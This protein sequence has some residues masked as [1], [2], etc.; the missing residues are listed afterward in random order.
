MT[1]DTFIGKLCTHPSQA[2]YVGNDHVPSNGFMKASLAIVAAAPL[3]A[4]WHWVSHEESSKRFRIKKK[5]TGSKG[6]VYTRLI[7]T[8][9]MFDGFIR[10]KIDS[11][12]RTCYES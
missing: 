8:H 12:G 6:V 4:A 11:V 3:V 2:Q 9:G 7:A 1:I 10:R 5:L